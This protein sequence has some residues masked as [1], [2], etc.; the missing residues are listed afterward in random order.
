M[1]PGYENSNKVDF[2]RPVTVECLLCHAGN[3]RPVP[4]TLNSYQTPP[5]AAEAITCDRC[6]G[7]AEAHLRNPVPGSIINPAKLPPHA[8]D[9]VCEQCYLQ[10]EA[11]I[12]NPGKKFSDFR[13]GENLENTFTVYVF[14]SKQ[15]PAA[16]KVISQS[17]QLPLSMCARMSHGHSANPTAY[18]RARCLSCHG[19][20][21]LKT[22]PKPNQNCIACHM[23]RLPVVNGNHTIFTDHRIAIYSSRE[24]GGHSHPETWSAE[25]ATLVPWRKPP[26]AYT[27]R[28][29]ALAD[30][31]GFPVKTP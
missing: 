6:H 2:Y 9:S 19:Q 3:P 10:G 5:F 8:R 31:G 21:L 22:H 13:P 7:S 29:L 28:N 20:S 25:T 11:R 18:F 4:D 12:A 15:N 24:L 23:P 26:A 14:A 17:Q 30:E 16:F 1:A 27:Q